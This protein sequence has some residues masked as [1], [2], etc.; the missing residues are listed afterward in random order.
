MFK[1]L[2][3][4]AIVIIAAVGSPA[5]IAHMVAAPAADSRFSAEETGDD[6]WRLTKDG[7]EQLAP[8][9]IPFHRAHQPPRKF[10]ADSD[11]AADQAGLQWDIHPAA[12]TLLLVVGAISA[13]CLFPNE[14][15]AASLLPSQTVF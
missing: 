7:W 11:S 5:L 12:L 15:S 6:G 10:P 4:T 13:F 14:R 1:R 3:H 2:A 9:V 8:R